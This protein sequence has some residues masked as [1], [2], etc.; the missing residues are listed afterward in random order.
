MNNIPAKKIIAD[1]SIWIE[2]LKRNFGIF[3]VMSK[4]LENNY[5]IGVECIFG[6]LLQGVKNRKER[7]IILAY[8][9]YIPK[10]DENDIWIES[11]DYSNKNGLLNK[12]I[13]LIDS[14]LIVLSKKNDL[15]LWTLDKKL[16]KICTE[17]CS[18]YTTDTNIT[19]G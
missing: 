8:W 10:V 13:G 5:I 3:P 17:F 11:G 19:F 9:E 4:L 16:E 7:D 2:F 1:T 12:G 15:M 18:I 14:V 6:E